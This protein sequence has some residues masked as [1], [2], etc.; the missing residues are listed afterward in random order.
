M[1]ILKLISVITFKQVAHLIKILFCV[2]CSIFIICCNNTIETN[3]QVRITY[4]ANEKSVNPKEEDTLSYSL[5]NVNQ[6]NHIYKLF[7]NNDTIYK[8]IV[9]KDFDTLFYF[10][11]KKIS[12]P[13][14]N[15][16]TYCAKGKYYNVYLYKIEDL[17]YPFYIVFTP[18]YGVLATKNVFGNQLFEYPDEEYYLPAKSLSLNAISDYRL[19]Y[20]IDTILSK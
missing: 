19:W 13:L 18:H 17:H 16:A 11:I 14:L 6:E 1:L 2:Y 4:F 9:K 20:P 8:L 5:I 12:S 3:K 10:R 15:G 7:R